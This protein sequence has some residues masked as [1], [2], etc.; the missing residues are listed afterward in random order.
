MRELAT[1]NIWGG[2]M[3]SKGSEEGT[4]LMC[5]K[6]KE[7]TMAG[8]EWARKRG[9]WGQR[10]EKVPG[11][12]GLAVSFWF[13]SLDS[14]EADHPWLLRSTVTSCRV[15]FLSLSS[16]YFS[17]NHALIS[18]RPTT[19][20][21]SCHLSQLES[22]SPLCNNQS[23]FSVARGASPVAQTVKNPLAMQETWVGSLGW[24]D[25]LEEGMATHCSILAWRSP[26]D[27]GGWR[28]TVHGV[29]KSWTRL[30]D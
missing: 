21:M 26:V 25:P 11:V 27:R 20:H 18:L 10:D 17:G 3:P 6:N 2:G 13:P 4:H 29:T 14:E 8:G 24:G 23:P 19:L 16:S 22:P 5:L 7:G 1:K 15:L 28:A 12:W 9:V 30:S